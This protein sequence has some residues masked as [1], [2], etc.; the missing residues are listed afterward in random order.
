[1]H[2][3]DYDLCHQNYYSKAH[4]QTKHRLLQWMGIGVATLLAVTI[5]AASTDPAAIPVADFYKRPLMSYA[6]LSPSGKHVAA[7]MKGGPNGREGLVIIDTVDTT[8]SKGLAVFA[9]ADVAWVRWVNDERLVFGVTDLK[10]TGGEELGGGLFAVDREG[11]ESAKNLIRRHLAQDERYGVGRA[12]SLLSEASTGLSVFHRFH[13]VLRDGSHDVI[14]QRRNIDHEYKTLGTSLLRLNTTNGRTKLITGDAPDFVVAWALD[15]RSNV[16]AA[17]QVRDGKSQLYWR[18]SEDAQWKRVSEWRTLDGGDK[19]AFPLAVD[20]ANRLY[21]SAQQTGADDTETLSRVSMASTTIEWKPLLALKGYDFHGS[22]VF[23]PDG[24][25]AGIHYLVDARGSH[26]FDAG[27]KAL[28]TSIDGALVG[29]INVLDCGNCVDPKVILVESYSDRQAVEWYLFDVTAKRLSRLAKSRP[30]LDSQ[31]MAAREMVRITARDGLS[32][33]AHVTKPAGRK[34]PLP[35]I[36]LV[37]GGPHAR[38]GEWEWEADSQFLAS[39]GYLVIEPEFRGSV[40]F[41]AKH[42]KAGWKQWGLAMQDDLA[43]AANWAIKQGMTD[44]KRICIAGASYG[45]YAT[46]MGLI[47]NPELFK[48]G[49][50]WVGV[51]D[52]DLLYTARWSD[53]TD[54]YKEY[55][56]PTLIGDREKDREQLNQTSPLKQA[57]KL[58]Q[59]ILLAYGGEDVRVPIAHGIAMRDALA[60]HNKNLEWTSYKDEGHGW[61][62][63]AN[64]ID[65]WTKVEKFLGKYLGEVK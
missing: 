52:I 17:L 42:Y 25:I 31:L 37:H 46:M 33:P 1:M 6:V 47:K 60:K 64:R 43:D 53:T 8:K 34:G 58:T 11:R 61:V 5:A 29:K 44:A 16:R 12:G 22:L 3:V 9:D 45:G 39:R 62:L 23:R 50:N 49:V 24:E 55:G 15:H 54:Q 56:M 10:L 59:P 48:C 51:S 30:W 2:R 57:A 35:T 28:Q 14:V 21:V 26:W 65:F 36:I 32:I 20:A 38:G 40:G 27:M 41:G 18:A 7:L 13:S 4:M 19:A 63:E